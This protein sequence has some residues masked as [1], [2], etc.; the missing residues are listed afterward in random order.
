MVQIKT[1]SLYF[2]FQLLSPPGKIQYIKT[3]HYETII[4]L[5]LAKIK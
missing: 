2:L 5:L 3:V 1:I 4:Y